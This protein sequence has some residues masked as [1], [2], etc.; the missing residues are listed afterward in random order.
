[1][2]LSGGIAQGSQ[3]DKGPDGRLQVDGVFLVQVV[4]QHGVHLGPVLVVVAAIGVLQEVGKDQIKMDP[5][6]HAGIVE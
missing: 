5:H 1:M 3:V 2:F 6:P 4:E